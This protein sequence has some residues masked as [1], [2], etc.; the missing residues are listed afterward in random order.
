MQLAGQRGPRLCKIQLLVG[1]VLLLLVQWRTIV[2]RTTGFRRDMLSLIG[3]SQWATLDHLI[4]VAGHAVLVTHERLT[5]ESVIRDD[6][7][8]LEPFQHGQVGTFVSH[9]K[10]G[11]HLAALDRNSLLLFSGGETREAA[12]PRSEAQSY[13]EVA[14]ALKW[15]GKREVRRRAL[16][17]EFAHDSFENVLFSFCRFREV[18]GHYPQKVTVVGF[19]F[20]EYRFSHMHR[21]ALRFPEDRWF[22]VGIDPP[23]GV[24]T[25]VR[26]GE[27][28]NSA[29]LFGADPYGCSDDGLIRKRATRNPFKT[30]PSYPRFCPELSDIFNYCDKDIFP[31]SLPW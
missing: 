6:F 27:R 18:T 25:D 10:K 21:A 30:S 8:T 15:D 4:I 13:W 11:I 19:A 29:S 17:E 9:I 16:T 26:D 22:Y 7:W 20:K 24:T 23:G 1:A 31:G 5:A 14:D 2:H 12:G 28:R 3:K